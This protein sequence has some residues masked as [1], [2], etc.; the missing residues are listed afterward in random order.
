MGIAGA[1]EG[2]NS[3]A[4]S[5]SILVA[6]QLADIERERDAAP[7]GSIQGQRRSWSPGWTRG[8]DKGGG[9]TGHRWPPGFGSS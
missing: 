2:P 3:C 1:A 5:S 7:T 4:N 6:R 8:R 9:V